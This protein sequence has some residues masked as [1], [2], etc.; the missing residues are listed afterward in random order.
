MKLDDVYLVCYFQIGLHCTVS[1]PYAI[2][3]HLDDQTRGVMNMAGIVRTRGMPL[4]ERMSRLAK[5]TKQL[6]LH[7]GGVHSTWK[8]KNSTLTLGMSTYWVSLH[9]QLG[10][11]YTEL[12]RTTAPYLISTKCIFQLAPILQ[13]VFNRLANWSLVR[14]QDY[15]PRRGTRW[16]KGLWMKLDNCRLLLNDVVC[17]TPEQC[18]AVLAGVSDSS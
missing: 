2:L 18:D 9:W 3:M 15:H 4:L 11:V 5:P 16:C 10:G 12:L 6:T 8:T 14:K 17:D 1:V 7:D 13:Y